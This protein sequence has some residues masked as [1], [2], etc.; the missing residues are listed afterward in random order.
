MIASLR[1]LVI[2]LFATFL[3]SCQPENPLIEE[4]NIGQEEVGEMDP[5]LGKW[6][7][8][9]HS[10]VVKG[11]AIQSMDAGYI[12]LEK[13]GKGEALMTH[14]GSDHS[15]LHP[16]NWIYDADY[17]TISIDHNDGKE[18]VLYLIKDQGESSQVW[19]APQQNE[20][21]ELEKITEILLQK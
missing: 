8:K 1:T 20:R 18:A 16:I 12:L 2:L 13:N 11:G 15:G 21:G 9:R 6:M 10:I 4:M 17:K 14:E 3:F 5:M 7:I 19:Q